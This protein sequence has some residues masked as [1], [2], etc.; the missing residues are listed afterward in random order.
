VFKPGDK[1][2]PI[3]E[4]IRGTVK[5]IISPKKVLVVTDDGFEIIYAI[6]ELV[7]IHPN[8]ARLTRFSKPPQKDSVHHKKSLSP[9]KN[10]QTGMEIDLHI[11]ELVD[12][13]KHMTNG[14]IVQVQLRHVK[15]ALLAAM[16]RKMTKLIIIHGRGEGVLRSE[17]RSI[18]DAYDNLEYL[19]APYVEYGS[20]AT[21]VRIWYK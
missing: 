1:V 4:P 3:D 8:T 5:E 21:E 19:D 2:A 11:Q 13:W 14:E 6:N 18:L 20:G 16:K 12:D 17:V 15:K 9:K 10:V 7:K